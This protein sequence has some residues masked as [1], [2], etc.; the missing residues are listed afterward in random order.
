MADDVGAGWH[1]DPTGRHQWRWWD[2]RA[3]TDHVAGGGVTGTDPIGGPPEPAARNPWVPSGGWAP[4]PPPGARTNG[5]ALAAMVVGIVAAFFS[6][7]VV[8]FFLAVPLGATAIGLGVAGRKRASE[9]PDGRG[10]GQATS[11]IVLGAIAVVLGVLGA[12]LVFFVIDWSED[13]GGSADPDTYEVDPGACFFEDGVAV[14]EGELEN[15]SG[16]VRSYEIVVEFEDD[17]GD[18]VA[19]ASEDLDDVVPD[20]SE[21]FRIEVDDARGIVDACRVTEVNEG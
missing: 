19:E 16:R 17:D 3:W 7:L 2:G 11:G 12:L 9:R 5:L 8:F 1:A 15:T 14:A 4:T 10:R 18:R 21:A 20:E 13:I 6:V